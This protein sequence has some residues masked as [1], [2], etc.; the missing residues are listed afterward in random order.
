MERGLP[1][2]RSFGGRSAK[3]LRHGHGPGLSFTYL[4]WRPF[5]YYTAEAIEGKNTHLEMFQVKPLD[6]GKRT[7]LTVR[8]KLIMPLPH[9]LKKIMA[10]MIARKL[11]PEFFERTRLLLAE[12]SVPDTVS[13]SLLEKSS[14]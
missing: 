12:L 9:S 7:R 4:D 6:D 14:P 8:V 5:Q 3:P 1:P 13:I 11:Y 10:N 2:R